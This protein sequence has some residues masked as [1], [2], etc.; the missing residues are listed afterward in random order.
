MGGSRLAVDFIGAETDAGGCLSPHNTL[1]CQA[2][3]RIMGGSGRR[4]GSRFLE[5]LGCRQDGAEPRRCAG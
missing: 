3:R 5:Q 4:S 1:I 2:N